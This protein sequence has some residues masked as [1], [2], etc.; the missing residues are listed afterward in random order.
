LSKPP[1]ILNSTENVKK[2][3]IDVLWNRFRKSGAS[4][5]T[6]QKILADEYDLDTTDLSPRIAELMRDGM[7]KLKGGPDNFRLTVKALNI[8][9]MVEGALRDQN[10]VEQ[11]TV[12]KELSSKSEK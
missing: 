4:A 5:T 10:S 3:V 6:V 11:T 2:A 7:L 8:C 1:Q 12:Q 9:E